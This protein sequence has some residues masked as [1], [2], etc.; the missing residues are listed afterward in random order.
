MAIRTRRDAWKLPTWDSTFLW[1]AHA[2]RE[3]QTRPITDSS[4]WAYQAAIHDFL[5]NTPHTPPLPPQL[6]RTTFWRQCQ[7]FCWFFLPWHRMYLLHFERSVAKTVLDLGGPADWALPYWN[8]SDA[9]NLNAR[10]IPPAFRELQTPDG[11]PNPLRIDERDFGND[12]EPVGELEDVDVCTALRKRRFVSQG[13]GGDPGFGGSQSG[14]NHGQGFGMIAGELERVPHGSI[15]VAVGGH[16][17]GFDTAGLDPLFWLH[18]ANIDRLWEVWRRRDS[19]NADP[20]QPLWL[21]G[22]PFAFHDQNGQEVAHTS[23]QVVDLTAPLLDYEYED[24][25]NPCTGLEAP[26]LEVDVPDR[27]PEMVGATHDPVALGTG[28]SVTQVSMVPPS[29]PMLETLEAAGAAPEVYLNVE[30]I[31]GTSKPVSYGV[32]LNV[33]EGEQPER[34]T[35]LFAGVLPMFGLAEAS[36]RDADHAG[37]GLHYTL[38]I[39]ELVR[40]LEAQGGWNPENVR[41]TFVPRRAGAQPGLEAPAQPIQVGRV[42]VYVG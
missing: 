13:F 24:V 3:M 15:H 41:V 34:H 16:M 28:P 17:S 6:E 22:V 29:G 12:G 36:Q 8:Y 42:S 23:S 33:P 32:Y 14:F 5:A 20:T 30:N 2:V 40:R 38:D 7:H 18:H 9:T 19:A 37:S 39:T 25:S 26:H 31:T 27:R 4:S 10:R 35:E 1:Y 21:T 11:M